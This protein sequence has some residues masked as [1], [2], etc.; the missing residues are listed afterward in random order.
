MYSL[1]FER[2]IRDTMHYYEIRH[3]TLRIVWRAS[4][5][6]C[7][8]ARDGARQLSLTPDR[9]FDSGNVR[10]TARRTRDTA[11]RPS[12]VLRDG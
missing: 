5:T 6:R 8:D 2:D 12:V 7:R 11:A 3:V 9:Q 4:L 1:L 10:Q